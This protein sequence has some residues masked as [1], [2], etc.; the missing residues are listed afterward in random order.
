MTEPVTDASPPPLSDLRADVLLLSAHEGAALIARRL[1]AKAA[2]QRVRLDD[3]TDVEGLHDFRVALRQLRSWLRALRPELDDVT[4]RKAGRAIRRIARASSDSRDGEVQL[5][6]LRAQGARLPR[7]ARPGWEWMVERV[8]R[9]RERS[10][11]RFRRRLTGEFDRA[12]KALDAALAS[13][14]DDAASASPVHARDTLAVA[15]A[16]FMRTQAERLRLH[17]AAV[18]GVG[19]ARE[20]HR[21]RIAGKRLRYVLQ[22][23][24][25]SL[26]GGSSAMDRLKPLQ[27][28]LGE[29]HDAHTLVDT[30]A[31]ALATAIDKRGEE[32]VAAIRGVGSG[33]ERFLEP[34]G[35]AVERGLLVLAGRLHERAARAFT[36]VRDSWL[37]TRADVLI[38]EMLAL[39]DQADAVAIRGSEVEIERKYLLRDLPDEARSAPAV[40]IEQGYLPG[41]RLT[42]RLRHL[43]DSGSERWVRTVKLGSGR[44]RTEIEEETTE[45]V[46]AVMWPLTEGR[47]LR[48]R[49]HAIVDGPLTWQIDEFLD[50]DLVLAEVELP[51][52]DL[53]VEPPD[54]LAPAV[55]REVTDEP[56][57]SNVN[58]AR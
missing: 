35:P 30:V 1:L 53:A 7:D 36:D 28:A 33:T 21:A 32:L 10:D 17:L 31:A 40:E 12:V 54:W 39:A 25:E 57:F 42:E 41:D 38:A 6:W 56:G 34:S 58:L 44:V 49:R 24:A 20:A 3:E 37:G 23:I 19:D 46:F 14:F 29:L 16:S 4:P 50:R 11:A 15:A 52:A 9:G 27:D 55:V 8:E 2:E 47:R 13:A 26:E 22:P 48:K 51:S 18:H 5:E 45:D 43:R